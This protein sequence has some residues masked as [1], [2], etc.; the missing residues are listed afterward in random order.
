MKNVMGLI[1]LNE[2]EQYLKDL[3]YDRTL[4][5][6]HFGGRYRII[7]FILSNLVNS[8]IRNVGLYPQTRFRSLMDH[9]RSG[10]EWDLDRKKD[11]LYILPPPYTPDAQKMYY[12]DLD[13][14]YAHR[15]YLYNSD[16]EE[17]VMCGTGMVCNIDF[18]EVIA[19]H[20]EMKADVTMVYTRVAAGRKDEI[21]YGI[22][23]ATDRNERVVTLEVEPE[24]T[25][26]DKVGME[27]YVLSKPLLFQIMNSCMS[28]GEYDF[29]K[30][31]L[32]KNLH[33]LNIRGYYFD[34][35]VGRIN[36]ISNYY[37]H[38]LDL[39]YPA[40]WHELFYQNGPIYTKVKDEAPTKY[41]KGAWVNNSLIASGCRIRGNVEN[42]LLFRR[43]E[44]EEGATVK[45][46]I[47]LPRS[48]VREGA[49]IENVVLDKNVQISKG[50]VM[51]GE[52]TYPIVIGRKSVI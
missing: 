6:V 40:I 23:L 8:G 32:V 38:N 39:L 14:I 27:M 2:R 43:V 24:E 10:K 36:S 37:Y 49:K 42:S 15:D 7:D 1:N 20:R 51:K 17:I 41:F 50:K 12:G 34:G 35:Y 18:K 45:N 44:I 4:G 30:A 3:T 28:R 46:S 9:L 16:Q 29:L 13:K 21:P 5:A 48:T 31:G 11:G 52:Q 25:N 33:S 26:L 47:V 19:Y 22:R